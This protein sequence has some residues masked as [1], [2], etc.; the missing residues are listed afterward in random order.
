MHSNFII[1]GFGR[2]GTKFLASKLNQSPSWKV[3]HE[4]IINKLIQD[5]SQTEIDSIQSQFNGVNNYGEVN[6][7][8][9][10]C[11]LNIDVSKKALL[12]R[13]PRDII[14]SSYNW[15][16]Q[17]LSNVRIDQIEAGF[18]ALDRLIESGIKCFLFERMIDSIDYIQSIANYVG[19]DDLQLSGDDLKPINSSQ[20]HVVKTY[21]DL[22]L[23]IKI[24]CTGFM[25]WFENKYISFWNE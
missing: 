7:Y 23:N 16:N 8:A 13:N 4:A 20:K 5:D 21:D 11:L 9:R 12:L 25:M 22:P 15:N 1:T 18:K 3:N 17:T 14:I 24:R 6:S 19:I 2:S 10:E